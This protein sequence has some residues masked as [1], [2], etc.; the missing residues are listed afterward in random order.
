[1]YRKFLFKSMASVLFVFLPMRQQFPSSCRK[2]LQ[3]DVIK[4]GSL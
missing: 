2:F 1:M 3:H 4:Y